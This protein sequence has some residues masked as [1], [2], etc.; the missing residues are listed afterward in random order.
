MTRF[1]LLDLWE[2]SSHKRIV[3]CQP[4]KPLQY[5]QLVFLASSVLVGNVV[6]RLAIENLILRERLL[7]S[8]RLQIV[9]LNKRLQ[10][11]WLLFL[12]F[13]IRTLI[14]R[15]PQQSVIKVSTMIHVV[16]HHVRLPKRR[17]SI[18]KQE[19]SPNRIAHLLRPFIFVTL[20]QVA[21]FRSVLV[22]RLFVQSDFQGFFHS[23]L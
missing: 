4:F 7:I 9:I 8:C 23:E 12:L 10:C 21:Q 1:L 13:V 16:N 19:L 17:Q 3:I 22:Y 15:L 20:A 5:S 18:L 11:F 14:T 2:Q 6:L